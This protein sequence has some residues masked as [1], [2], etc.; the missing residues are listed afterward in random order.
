VVDIN[1]DPADFTVPIGIKDI[2]KGLPIELAQDD[3]QLLKYIHL[4]GIVKKP[5]SADYNLTEPDIN[6]S[7]GQGQYIQEL[8]ENKVSLST[9]LY[10]SLRKVKSFKISYNLP[11]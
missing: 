1:P 3:P 4:S 5:S 10:Y 7:M 2:M 6:P 11:A 8:F 9:I